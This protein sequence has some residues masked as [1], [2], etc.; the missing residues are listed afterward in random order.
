L[1]TNGSGWREGD[2][3]PDRGSV[4]G[5]RRLWEG[6]IIREGFAASTIGPHLVL[7]DG[8]FRALLTFRREVLVDHL[9]DRLEEFNAR[10]REMLPKHSETLNYAK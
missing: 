8:N 5:K 6:H 1:G 4:R 2:A 10:I 7:L 9:A 3:I